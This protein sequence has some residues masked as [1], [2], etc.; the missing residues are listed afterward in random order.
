MITNIQIQDFKSIT[1]LS[2]DLGR[3]NVFIGANGSGKSNILEAIAM[4]AS[5]RSTQIEVKELISKGVRVAKPYLMQSSFP[6]HKTANKI[7][8]Q[9]AFKEGH[10]SYPITNENPDD[11]YSPWNCYIKTS[12]RDEVSHEE[13]DRI[14]CNNRNYVSQFLIYSTSITALRGLSNESYQ[15]PLGI[16]GEGLDVLLNNLPAEEIEQIKAVAKKCISWI[17]DIFF[18][19][20]E[21]Y[22]IHGYKLG[23]SISNLYFIDKYMEQRNNIFS[24]ENANEGALELLFYLTLFVA[25]KTPP[26]FAIDNIE[27]GLNPRLCRFLIKNISELAVRN[28]KQAIITTHNPATLDGLN[29]YDDD[30]RLFVVARNDEGHTVAKRIKM[31]PASNGSDKPMLSELWMKGFLG[32]LPDNF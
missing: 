10:L 20:E 3:V 22:K 23:R 8:L 19:P 18:D 4:A 25:Q 2:L 9:M 28:Q 12:G 6:E 31:K 30:Q 24:A 21:R 16:Y 11:I 7:K 29:L 32:G 1:D 26:F 13:V 17:D 15:Y 14:V 27:T 5:V